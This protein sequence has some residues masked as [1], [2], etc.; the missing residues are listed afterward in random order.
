MAVSSL[1]Y[2]EFGVADVD[3]WTRFAVDVLGLEAVAGPPAGEQLLRLDDRAWRLSLRRDSGDDLLAVGFE[4]ADAAELE[5]TASALRQAG[6]EPRPMS[7]EEAARRTAKGGF[8]V[9]DPAGLAVELVHGIEAGAGATQATGFLTG[10]QGLGHLVIS[11]PDP[12][13]ALRFYG[14]L[15]FA[16]SDYIVVDLGPAKGVQLTFLHCNARHHTLALLPLPLPKRLNHLMLEV[17]N[18]DQVL[19][20]YYR[21]I[22]AGHK[23][24][25][26]MGRHTN[27]HMLSFYVQTPA[28]FDVEFGTG[29]RPI[30]PGWQTA[31]Y[32]AISL[33]G[34]AP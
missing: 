26:H 13:A 6:A 34:H 28:G 15:G 24:V 17:D 8:I 31:T 11:A 3:A 29:G 5:R 19:A 32:D 25:R 4:V 20:A 23:I 27:D 18:V 16:V 21:A 1:A 14:A 2:A 12:A 9:A 30:T 33:W 7:G 22:A 10:A